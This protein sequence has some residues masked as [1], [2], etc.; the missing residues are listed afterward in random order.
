MT[1]A[2]AAANLAQV[3]G[4]SGLTPLAGG[5]TNLVWRAGDRVLKL[6]RPERATPLFTNDPDAEWRVLHALD[7]RRIGPVPRERGTSPF[8]PWMIAD[9]LPAATSG[10]DVA[11]LARLLFRVHSTAPPPGL[12]TAATGSAVIAQG[13]AMLPAGHPLL[14][15]PVPPPPPDPPRLCLIHRDPVPTNVIFTAAGARLVDWQ[16]PALGDPAE[17]LAHALSPA[18]HVLYTG[19]PM[20]AKDQERFLSAYPDVEIVARYRAGEAA[21]HWRM[22]VYC[23]WQVARGN[24]AYEAALQAGNAVSA[25]A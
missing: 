1:N 15:R 16:C 17:D 10:N 21:W 6:Y 4:L 5:R 2:A 19:A 7:G 9:W 13:R 23:A 14:L 24:H 11:D 18:M 25:A 20:S 8:G 12:T 22:S 3:T